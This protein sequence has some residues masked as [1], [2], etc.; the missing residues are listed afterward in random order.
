MTVKELSELLDVQTHGDLPVMVRCR[1]HGD[2]PAHDLFDPQ[3]VSLEL[4][5]DTA[6]E[7]I[8]IECQQNG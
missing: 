3:F 7:Q 6:E 4:E 8:V 2:A 1:W 5:P